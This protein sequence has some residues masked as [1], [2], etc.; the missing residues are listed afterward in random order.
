MSDRCEI[1]LGGFGGQGVVTAG[2]L[3]GRAANLDGKEAVL[4]KAYG[5]EIRGA[6]VTADVIIASEAID[7]PQTEA[8][9]LLVCFS[10]EAYDRLS[11]CLRPDGRVFFDDDLVRPAAGLDAYPINALHTAKALGNR[12]VANII[13]LGYLA[14]VTAVVSREALERAMLERMPEKVHDLNRRALAAGF[15][16]RHAIV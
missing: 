6:S 9:D 11:P 3:L 8:P 7:Y 1:R 16:H 10:Q 14:E 15:E 12:V 2:E 4:T 5:P 13:M